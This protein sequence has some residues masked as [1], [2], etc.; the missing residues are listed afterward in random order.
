VTDVKVWLHCHKCGAEQAC[1]AND[2]AHIKCRECYTSIPVVRY[3]E[4]HP[5]SQIGMNVRPYT[6][7]ATSNTVAIRQPNPPAQVANAQIVESYYEPAS[8]VSITSDITRA[9]RERRDRKE[10]I[11]RERENPLRAQMPPMPNAR[12]CA[13]CADANI[14]DRSGKFPIATHMV[15]TIQHFEDFPA[16]H[17][18]VQMLRTAHM[19]VKA[20]AINHKPNPRP[21]YREM[22]TG[23]V[24]I[25]PQV[26]IYAEP[27]E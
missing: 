3:P 26:I 2:G 18:H 4:L 23:D 13:F 6:A 17:I 22:G 24:P 1:A 10:S 8:A 19:I 5:R 9:V 20:T 27:S 15:K 12:P 7:P 14:H 21:S 11:Q 25:N 16:C